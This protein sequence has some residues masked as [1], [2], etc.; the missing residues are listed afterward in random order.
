[1]ISPHLG[2]VAVGPPDPHPCSDTVSTKGVP[3]APDLVRDAAYP[4]MCDQTASYNLHDDALLLRRTAKG[5]PSNSGVADDRKYAR[6]RSCP[7]ARNET[8]MTHRW[9]GSMDASR[10][11]DDPRAVRSSDVAGDA[12]RTPCGY[13][14]VDV[15]DLIYY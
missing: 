14:V 12:A 1:M 9:S 7:R 3:P 5:A 2:L 4:L 15:G 10:S 6:P 13:R 11:S 8:R